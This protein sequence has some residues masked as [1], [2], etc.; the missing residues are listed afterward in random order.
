[1]IKSRDK[2]VLT[3]EE[4]VLRRCKEDFEELMNVKNEREEDR[5]RTVSES[6]SAQS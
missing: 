6:R 4:H 3:S 1:M 5:W 2:N